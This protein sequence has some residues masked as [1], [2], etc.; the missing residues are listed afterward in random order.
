MRIIIFGASGATGQEV[1]KQALRDDHFV[2][3]FVRNPSKLSLQH[4]N[5]AI[6]QGDVK[7][8]TVVEKAIE[9]QD[10]V[11]S[12]LG[13]STPLHKDPVVVEGIKS[14]LQAM[15]KLPVKRFIY[16][17]FLAVGQGRKDAGFLIKHIISRVVHHEIEDHQEKEGFIKASHLDW[18]IIH[19]PKLTNGVKKGI[20]RTGES[21]Q[22]GSFF[23]TLSRAD[24]ADFMIKQLN[25]NRFLRK[26]VRIMY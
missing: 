4:N 3:A 22:P 24:L 25:D 26:T 14:I 21:I 2:T 1:V 5:L 23:P 9:G 18:T 8:Y 11:L 16:L 19:P 7:D 12:A 17:S 10:A 13:V 6:V 20:Y 15:E